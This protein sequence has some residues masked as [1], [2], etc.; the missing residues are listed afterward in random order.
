MYTQLEQR[1]MP[2]PPVNVSTLRKMKSEGEA[3]AC[4]TAYD[5]S[6]AALVDTAGGL[7]WALL[8]ARWWLCLGWP[9]GRTT[10]RL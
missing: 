5:A 8:R 1:G 9:H 3:I 4:V 2:E 6:Y 7:L 10:D